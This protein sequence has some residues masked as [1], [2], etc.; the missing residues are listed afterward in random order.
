MQM[1]WTWIKTHRLITGAVL[2]VIG[3]ILVLLPSALRR[4][5]VSQ[6]AT[7]DQTVT[8]TQPII[9]TGLPAGCFTSM[10]GNVIT[11][12]G[13]PTGGLVAITATCPASVIQIN[14]HLQC[15]A[16]VTGNTNTQVT[17]ATS[18]GGIASVSATGEVIGLG[19]GPV[20]ITA[21]SQADTSK[22]SLVSLTVAAVAS[23]VA[24]DATNPKPVSGGTVLIG[25]T[26]D[27]A[28]PPAVGSNKLTFQVA[29]QAY[30]YQVNVPV[31]G[32]YTINAR[33]CTDQSTT[34]GKLAVHFEMP[35]GTPVS[36][37]LSV[38]APQQWITVSSTQTVALVA[39]TN[40]IRLIVDSLPTGGNGTGFI[41]WF[42]FV[43]STTAA[44]SVK[45]TWQQ[46][47]VT[48]PPCTNTTCPAPP[49]C[50][51]QPTD[52]RIYRSQTSGVYQSQ[53]YA[54][55]SALNLSF[56]DPSVQAGQTYYYRVTAYL[57]D[58][59]IPESGPSNEVTAV[60]PAAVKVA[61]AKKR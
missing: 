21:T 46:G 37:S 4:S 11:V 59:C 17:W 3:I 13:C 51:G 36:T 8:L 50:F 35:A 24:R 23:M 14:Q 47:A 18:D 16:T 52:I 27:P 61:K 12:S 48:N 2:L 41:H 26:N 30:E 31:A 7:G 58:A 34:A 56:T 33:I 19:P 54:S 38:V 45:L 1:N 53:Y 57:A 40:T 39:G 55:T 49:N 20:N 10:S 29:K 60:I 44:H 25:P 15:S 6:F 22:A 5:G 28:V 43:P 9:I 42:Q 32:N